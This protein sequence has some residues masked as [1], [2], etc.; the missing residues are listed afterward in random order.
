MENPYH[1]NENIE[2]KY[3]NSM[4]KNQFL[5]VKNNLLK[6]ERFFTE[7]KDREFKGRKLKIKRESYFWANYRVYRWYL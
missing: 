7:L 3:S 6:W 1:K 4:Q 2:T 5:K